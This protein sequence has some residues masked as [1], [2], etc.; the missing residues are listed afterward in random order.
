MPPFLKGNLYTQTIKLWIL[1]ETENGWDEMA[2]KKMLTKQAGK[3][4]NDKET[5][6][7]H[8]KQELQIIIPQ[9]FLNLSL[10]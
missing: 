6:S 4:R 5:K 8:L 10:I 1:R 7:F 9:I 3:Q 2:A